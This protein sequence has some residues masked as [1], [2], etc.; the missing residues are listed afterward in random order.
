M[1]KKFHFVVQRN[2]FTTIC[3]EIIPVNTKEDKREEWTRNKKKR[4]TK[5]KNVS[6]DV[7]VHREIAFVLE[8]N[9][10]DI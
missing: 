3:S 4:S 7:F 6:E 10:P 5:I 9:Y 2:V 1:W 8:K